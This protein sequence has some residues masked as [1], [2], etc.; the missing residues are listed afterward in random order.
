MPACFGEEPLPDCATNK[1]RFLH[2]EMSI[3]V[4]SRNAVFVHRWKRLNSSP[5]KFYLSIS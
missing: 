3:A 5:C 1:W 4:K 2:L